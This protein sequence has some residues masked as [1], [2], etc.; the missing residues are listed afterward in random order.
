[1][2]L[3]LFARVEGVLVNKYDTHINMQAAIGPEGLSR[4]AVFAIFIFKI[5]P[6]FSVYL[7]LKNN[8]KNMLVWPEGPLVKA[9]FGWGSDLLQG[10]SAGPLRAC[11]GREG[12]ARGDIKK[13]KGETVQLVGIETNSG[14][15]LMCRGGEV[16]P[17]PA[18]IGAAKVEKTAHFISLSVN[19]P[20][21]VRLAPGSARRPSSHMV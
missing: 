4:S 8:Q 9:R 5:T 20:G 13:C 10:C 2:A 19:L 14:R 15:H 7:I 11:G 17:G 21:A 12:I 1:M 3:G 6:V 16:L 18:T